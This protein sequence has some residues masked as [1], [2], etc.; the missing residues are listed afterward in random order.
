MPEIKP[1]QL[2]LTGDGNVLFQSDPTNPLSGVP[3]ARLRKGK[4]V[5]VPAFDLTDESFP[6][7]KD[8]LAA[9]L[10]GHVKDV[11]GALLDLESTDD[12]PGPVRGICFQIY[13]AMG[14]V[15]REALED[16]I[17]SL[18]S[19]MRQTLRAKQI[20]LGPILVFMP[21]LNKPA[22]VRLRALLWTIWNDKPLPAAVPADGIVSFKIDSGAID[23]RFYQAVGYPVY[24]PRAIRIDMLDRVINAVYENAK[25]G[26]FRAEHK[27]AEWL[28]CSIDDLYAVLE[29][30][31]H[32]KIEEPTPAAEEPKTEEVKPEEVKVEAKPVLALFRLKKGKAFEKPVRREKPAGDK[33]SKK[34][35]GKKSGKLHGHDRPRVISAAAPDAK[36]DSPFAVLQQLKVKKDAAGS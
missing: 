28:G 36:S 12:L 16:L 27:M 33:K 4:S 2:K 9:W 35:D 1:E 32:R 22:A 17:G 18:D 5:L 7:T 30:M 19:G 10:H 21:V 3:V 31:G 15:P 34:S 6:G 20:R 26:K 23:R 14:I 25:E 11:I 8:F 13:E 29:A 24:G